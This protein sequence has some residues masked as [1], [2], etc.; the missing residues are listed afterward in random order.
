MLIYC[1]SY[2]GINV[3]ERSLPPVFVV[4]FFCFSVS[5]QQAVNHVNGQPYE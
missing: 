5:H 3:F 2:L 4:F 1:C